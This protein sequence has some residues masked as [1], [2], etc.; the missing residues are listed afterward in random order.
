VL[1]GGNSAQAPSPLPVA[2]T[3]TFLY[4]VPGDTWQS[5]CR[6]PDRKYSTKKPLPMYSSPNFLAECHTRKAFA[7]CFPRFTECFR[8]STKKLFPVVGVALVGLCLLL[9]R[10]ALYL[11]ENVVC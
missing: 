10:F 2:L 11:D 5:L 6:V 8:Y 3:V 9:N 4:R 7:E 1:L